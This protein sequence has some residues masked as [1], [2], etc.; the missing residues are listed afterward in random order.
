MMKVSADIAVVDGGEEVG[1]AK[2]EVKSAAVSVLLR[3]E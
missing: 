2:A 1:D 3:G